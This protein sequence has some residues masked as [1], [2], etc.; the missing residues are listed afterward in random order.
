[1]IASPQIVNLFW[2]NNWDL[3]NP[4]SPTR[5]QINASAQRV[6]ASEYLDGA[7]QYGV[8]RGMFVAAHASST[9][10]QTMRPT[11]PN[12]SF[13]SP[14]NLGT[15]N[16]TPILGW[17]TCE[18]EGALVTGVPLPTNNT[19][20]AIYLPE[21]IKVTGQPGAPCGN[22]VHGFHMTTAVV[23]PNSDPDV[24]LG[25][26]Y[27]L[28]AIPIIVMPAQCMLAP[29]PSGTIDEYTQLF[30]H[31]L[32]EASLDP[33]APTGWIDNRWAP[34]IASWTSKG[35]PA[36]ICQNGSPYDGFP[37]HPAG[38][39]T[40]INTGGIRL[41]S[42][43]AVVDRY[44]S[45]KDKQCIPIGPSARCNGDDN[46]HDHDDNHRRATT[47]TLPAKTLPAKTTP[48]DDDHH[49]AGAEA[50]GR[51]AGPRRHLVAS[52]SRGNCGGGVAERRGLRAECRRAGRAPRGGHLHHRRW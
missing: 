43:G 24:L 29:T 30:S 38:L 16:I 11:G 47:K 35:E 37:T 27:K 6:A 7:N 26:V 32:V 34:D 8:H 52:R 25:V 40:G 19:I 14:T 36:D 4:N 12:G 28:V 9:L 10:C 48:A 49:D 20:Y 22:G 18:I 31:E 17:V 13:A 23:L 41:K 45:N 5:A 2:D 44:W 21:G 33:I 51:H 46:D 50:A 15:M 3:H 1:M 42:N 39:P